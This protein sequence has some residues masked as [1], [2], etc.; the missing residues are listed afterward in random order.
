MRPSVCLLLL[1]LFLFL[2]VVVLVCCC[3]T[4]PYGRRCR[5]RRGTI[6]FHKIDRD[7]TDDTRESK[8]D[9]RCVRA[10]D[11]KIPPYHR[12]PRR[13]T[14]GRCAQ[15]RPLSRSFGRLRASC[16]LA[17]RSTANEIGRGLAR[18]A[19]RLNSQ[20]RRSRVIALVFCDARSVGEKFRARCPRDRGFAR[21]RSLIKINRLVQT[22]RI[23]RDIIS[24]HRPSSIT[25]MLQ[26][27]TKYFTM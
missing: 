14:A 18:R 13:P 25:S 20:R 26:Y 1:L 27:F 19:G 24:K 17:P 2:N 6:H 12:E 7:R 22:R 16:E 10:N 3:V 4:L 11:A 23:L 15:V 21:H 8:F 9:V 5:A